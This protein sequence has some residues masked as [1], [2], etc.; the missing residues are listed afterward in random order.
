MMPKKKTA[1]IKREVFTA[2]GEVK[3][4][5][6]RKRFIPKSKRYLDD[7]ISRLPEG[8]LL[9]VQFNQYKTMRS[10]DQLRYHWVLVGYLSAHTGYPKEEMHDAL[11]RI[12]FGEKPLKLGK[13]TIMV[14]K[15]LSDQGDLAKHE[16]VELI[17]RDLALC[18]EMEIRVPTRE[19]LGYLPG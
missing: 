8:T 14:R 16:V 12:V 6:G 13:N 1:P 5:E 19:E 18:E 2:V 7:Q 11:M 4:V 15:S 10:H 9:S 17:E 3:E